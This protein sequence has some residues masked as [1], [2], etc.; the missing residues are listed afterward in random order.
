M[1][2]TSEDG[3]EDIGKN[4][5]GEDW[6]TELASA[7]AAY[8][9]LMASDPEGNHDVEYDA[10]VYAIKDAK[11]IAVAYYVEV[12]KE[13]ATEVLKEGEKSGNFQVYPIDTEQIKFGRD[14]FVGDIVTVSVDG[15]EYSDM[16]REVN[17]TV[18]DGGKAH[19][20]SPKIGE[21]GSGDPLNLCSTVFEMRKKLRKLEARM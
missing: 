17:I 1:T 12:I 4:A 3:I 2:T 16:V 6:T 8:E 9:A 20:V 15:T 19:T 10:L 14:Y 7:R 11:P 21:Q 18:D 5:D 13:A